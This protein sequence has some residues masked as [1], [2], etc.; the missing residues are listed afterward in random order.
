MDDVKAPTPRRFDD[1][2]RPGATPAA[3]SANPVIVGNQTLQADPM[4]SVAQPT[5]TPAPSIPV[6]P[7][8]GASESPTPTSE[9]ISTAVDSPSVEPLHKFTHDAPMFGEMKPKAS[10]RKKLF[11]VLVVLLIIGGLGFGAW[12]FLINKKEPTSTPTPAVTSQ[13]KTTE[14][15]SESTAYV[16]PANYVT[17]T[18]ATNKFSF[19]YPKQYLTFK[20]NQPPLADAVSAVFTSSTLTTDLA[21]GVN[22]PFVVTTYKTKDAKIDS[23]KYGPEI[24][25]QNGKWIVTKV[26]V[27]D[28]DNNKVG[29]EYTG[30]DTM[31]VTSQKNGTVTVYTFAS[32]DEGSYFTKLLFVSNDVFNEITLPSFSDGTYG[33]PANTKANDKTAYNTM[34]KNVTNS[35]AATKAN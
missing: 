35:V 29:A 34:V 7:P 31:K 33:A 18:D 10:P 30:L 21:P 15:K 26:N 23:R 20:A 25:L 3:P 9:P 11:V 32:A 14:E 22:G 12:Y 16:A 8:R 4:M 1:V 27:S 13:P 5:P 24:Q 17:Y 19:A 6:I 2:A 28:I